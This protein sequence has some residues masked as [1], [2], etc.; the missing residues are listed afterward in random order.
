M[1]FFN[2]RLSELT[3]NTSNSLKPALKM[4]AISAIALGTLTFGVSTASASSSKLSTV[5]YVYMN[6]EYVGT[7][8]DKEVVQ[9]ILDEK[10]EEF[11]QTYTNLDLAVESQLTYVSEQV[12]NSSAKTNDEEVAEIIQTKM[13]VQANA[14]ALVIDGKA[15]AYLKS[16]AEADQVLN[17]LKLKYVT[18]EQL[19]E[20]ETR[21]E[22]PEVVLPQL[23]ENEVRLLDV[24]FTKEV[25]QNVEK[26]TPDKILTVEE[27]VNLLTKGTL[28]EKKYS[29]KEGDV[30]GGI[31]GAHGME[32][33]QLLAINPGMTEDSVLKIGQEL[34]VTFLQP[35]LQVVVAKEEAKKETIAF[36]SQVIED[37]SMYKG[38]TKVEQE[39]KEGA[40][41]VTYKVSEQNGVRVAQEVVSENIL[42]E[43]V[44][45]IVRK[46][47]KVVPSRGD[48]SLAWP[49]NGGYISSEVGYR[50]GSYHK[51]IDIARPSN[52]TIKA[53]D[54]GT[55]VSAGYDGGYGNKVI[56]DHNNG[57]RTVYAHL[58]SISVNVGQTVSKGS[59][60][61]V[62]G[63]TGNSTGIHLHFEVY[64][65][66]S[67]QNPRDYLN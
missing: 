29:V 38:D 20:L 23:K 7:V 60:I 2:K 8:S 25:S 53:A 54:N 57:M 12:F 18:Q 15:V 66:G 55:V 46:G 50:W 27:A 48:G 33:S 22:T 37:A 49:A 34:N 19:T 17:A 26:V 65:N 36:A 3:I 13:A 14:S 45:Y 39:G 11:K 62:M 58:A 28:E 40:R 43:P 63:D 67:L 61:G 1:F 6:K 64:K 51:G 32:T 24:S 52:R 42:Q 56:I 59:A 44:S 4:A 47:T 35:L 41:Q 16:E 5:Y 10:V 21:K 30:L 31:A 9:D